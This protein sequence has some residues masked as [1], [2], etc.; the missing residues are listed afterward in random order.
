MS[1]LW[2]ATRKGLFTF[3]RGKG[4]EVTR[5]A[6][7]GDPASIV[8]PDARTGRVYAALK[9]EQFGTKLH[10]NE[11]GETWSETGTPTYPE[12]PD[13]VPDVL[14]PFRQK[15]IPWDL[16]MI[17]SLEPGGDDQP[18]RLWCGT[19]PG[20]VFTSDDDGQTWELN[21]PLWDEPKRAKWFGGGYDFPGIHS[22]CV[23]PRDSGIV[24][25]GISCGGAWATRDDGRTWAQCAHGMRNA[26]MPPD[27]A[28]DPDSQDPHRV[29]QCPGQPDVFWAQHHNGIF[30]STNGSQKWDEIEEAGPSVFGFTVAVH[31]D[32]GDT[33]WF[34]PAT[35]DEV[36]IPVDGRFVVTRT[37]DGGKSFDVLT[38][39]LPQ[40]P[41]YDLVY[42]H[43]LDV[44]ATGDM[45]AVGSTTG[46]L[47]ISEDQ[48]DTW[49]HV[50]GHLPPIYA[51]RFG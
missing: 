26:Y 33:A 29:V 21:R 17:W 50:N 41:S 51:V 47:W 3:E 28:Y 37:R 16:Q 22:I 42:R 2:V 48:G 36:R 46:S 30:R 4:W 34:V 7:L 11:D 38:R 44:D 5:T 35:K 23:D 27:Q 45:L 15:P 32:D 31:P 25:V 12:K 43:A 14:E 1:R 8:M 13:G 40:S 10:V 24:R 18:G 49:E 39:G 6:F 9:H 20:G 19:I